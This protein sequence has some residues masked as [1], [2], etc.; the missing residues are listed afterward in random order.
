M[1]DRSHLIRTP[2]TDRAGRQTTVYR[3]PAAALGSAAALP[4]PVLAALM[5]PE[6]PAPVEQYEQRRGRIHAENARW[7]DE[8]DRTG[9]V[10]AMSE[11]LHGMQHLAWLI[12]E[13]D[14]RPASER[15]AQHL[16]EAV[17]LHAHSCVSFAGL[18]ARHFCVAANNPERTLHD[19]D[20]EDSKYWESYGA[21]DAAE[22]MTVART[23]LTLDLI[24]FTED[25]PG[26]PD[27]RVSAHL[28]AHAM[29]LIDYSRPTD[30]IRGAVEAIDAR[31]DDF[32]TISSIHEPGMH[33]AAILH[34]LD[35][36]S[37]P[38]SRGAL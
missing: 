34:V 26:T 33:A 32:L 27:E 17:D 19:G 23:L 9:A 7:R 11:A 4:A 6:P 35:S 38:L 2:I 14:Y 24:S 12:A 29:H 10:E 21:A 37:K 13:S 8:G 25:F 18:Y 3:R 22:A 15:L 16:S 36:T 30:E 1:N 20:A 5:E 31:P 28:R